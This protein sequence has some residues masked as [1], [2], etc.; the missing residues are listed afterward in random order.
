[1]ISVLL[2]DDHKIVRQGISSALGIDSSIK[3]VGE[4]S[5]GKMAVTMAKQLN[6]D[7]IIMDI[8]MPVMDGIEASKEIKKHNEET[9]IL[10]LTMMEEKNYVLDALSAGINGYLYKM[11]GIDDLIYA[12]KLIAEGENYFD[13]R[14]TRIL[15]ESKNAK[16]ENNNSLSKR[17]KEIL[18]HI[19]FGLTSKEIGNKLF[20]ST[21][22]VQKHRKNILHKLNL[23]G[24]AELVKYGIQNNLE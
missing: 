23:K 24:T 4:A 11:S 18:K 22:T 15:V 3:I 12:V 19:V 7:I 1:M 2:V 14:V 17:E 10:M 5:D 21:F 13:S 9:K 16:E 20:I 8:N 6:P